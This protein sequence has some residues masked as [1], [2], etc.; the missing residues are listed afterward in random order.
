[1]SLDLNEVKAAQ[2]RVYAEVSVYE[3]G[4]AALGFL[5][6]GVVD[7]LVTEVERLRHVL[8]THEAQYRRHRDDG[9]RLSAKHERQRDEARAALDR[10][11]A[12]WQPHLDAVPLGLP[13]Q[14]V[15]CQMGRA[16]DGVQPPHD[17]D[18]TAGQDR[19]TTIDAITHDPCCSSHGKAL[20]CAQYRRTHFVEVRP[21]CAHDAR[22]LDGAS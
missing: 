3:K 5:D 12:V 19:R 17:G 6:S 8:E 4:D 2:A 21:C 9:Y 20:T 18:E 15:G 11:R 16:I 13:C 14:C 7:D 22:A 1:M 10:V